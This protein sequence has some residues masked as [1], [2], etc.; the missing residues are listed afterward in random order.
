[1]FEI[2][3]RWYKNTTVNFLPLSSASIAGSLDADVRVLETDWSE[4][5]RGSKVEFG[6]SFGFMMCGEENRLIGFWT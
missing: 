6:A 1:M 3:I 4:P 2:V 5:R